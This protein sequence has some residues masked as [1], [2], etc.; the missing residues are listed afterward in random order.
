LQATLEVRFSQTKCLIRAG[1]EDGWAFGIEQTSVAQMAEAL[2]VL[3]VAVVVAM[4]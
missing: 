3:V 4:L 2:V 1:T